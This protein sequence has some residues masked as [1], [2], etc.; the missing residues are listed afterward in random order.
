MVKSGRNIPRAKT[1]P[2]CFARAKGTIV[3]VT[4]AFLRD[5]DQTRDCRDAVGVPLSAFAPALAN[6]ARL[7]IIIAP[8]LRHCRWCW[9]LVLPDYAVLCGARVLTRTARRS[10]FRDAGDGQAGQQSE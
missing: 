1:E 5:V 9:R 2:R 7:H 3:F 4:I 6:E 8:V 10:A